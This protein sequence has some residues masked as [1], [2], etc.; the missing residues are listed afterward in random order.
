MAAQA[1]DNAVVVSDIH[2]DMRDEAAVAAALDFTWEVKPAHRICLGDV[3]DF[4]PFRTRA[5]EEEKRE[6]I[7]A[8]FDA[9]MDFLR[10]FRPTVLT[11]GN[12]D[13]R[14][15]DLAQARK[16][17]LSDYAAEKVAEAEALLKSLKTEVLPYHK[18]RGVWRRG[19]LSFTHGFAE[20]DN[21]SVT[22]ARAYGNVLYGH[23]H[24]V[25]KGLVERH[26]NRNVAWCVGALCRIDMDYNA[27][28]LKT[29]RQE[30]SFALV[31][32]YGRRGEDFAVFPATQVSSGRFVIPSSTRMVG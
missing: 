18:R 4:R 28:Q 2:G 25:D 26:P 12:H 10:R 9:G 5:S 17:P 20:G 13:Q 30:N 27:R 1:T 31:E 21:A 3:W 24:V 16:G 11:L 22:M 14:L 8:D 29:L 23:R 15:W 32:W 6:S 19:D 7:R